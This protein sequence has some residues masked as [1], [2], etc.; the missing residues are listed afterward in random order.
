M[1]AVQNVDLP[2]NYQT[3]YDS[4][5]KIVVSYSLSNAFEF[6]ICVHFDCYNLY[7]KW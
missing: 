5:T 6:E 7:L 1:P 2:D 3:K 4:K